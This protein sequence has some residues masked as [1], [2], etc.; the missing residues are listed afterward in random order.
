MADRLTPERRSW[1]MSRIRGKDT[2]PELKLRSLL[3][4]AG[5]RFRLHNKKLP[6]RPDL[7]LKKY[8]T[9][10]FV[11]GCYWH[12]HENC[13]KATTP[14]TKTEF[15]TSKFDRTMARDGETV[16]KLRAA[17]WKVQ[18]VWECELERDPAKALERVTHELRSA[19]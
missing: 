4:R 6:G 9:T 13:S 10:I 7:T 16:R 19:C 8:R 15:W 11:H 2:T 17:G 3:H 1:N 12:R 18:I 5:F 14:S